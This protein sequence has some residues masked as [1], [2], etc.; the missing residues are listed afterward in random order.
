MGTHGAKTG[1]GNNISSYETG[2]LKPS[3]KTLRKLL[4]AFSSTLDEFHA[5]DHTP[6][7]PETLQDRE[8]LVLLQDL[9]ALPEPCLSGKLA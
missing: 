8:L 3:D 1:L 5:D 7:A 4:E 2:H 9:S 6:A